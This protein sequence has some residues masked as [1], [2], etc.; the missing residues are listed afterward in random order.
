MQKLP[1][2]STFCKIFTSLF[3]PEAGRCGEKRYDAHL[4]LARYGEHSYIGGGEVMVQRRALS[5]CEV[6]RLFCAHLHLGWV[7]PTPPRGLHFGCVGLAGFRPHKYTSKVPASDRW[8]KMV[9]DKV[10]TPVQTG[11][12]MHSHEHTVKQF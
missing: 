3:S 4:S 7:S 10:E 2:I 12:C 1:I 6:H 9:E 5:N 8:V 11:L